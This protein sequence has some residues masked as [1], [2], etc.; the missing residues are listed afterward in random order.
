M[1]SSACRSLRSLRSRR[2]LRSLRSLRSQS[3]S[4][5][6]RSPAAILPRASATWVCQTGTSSSPVDRHRI[7]PRPRPPGPRR[8]RTGPRRS[9]TAGRAVARARPVHDG[10]TRPWCPGGSVGWPSAMASALVMAGTTDASA[11]TTSAIPPSA[12]RKRHGESHSATLACAETNPSQG[13]RTF[14]PGRPFTRTPQAGHTP[15]SP[16]SSPGR[17]SSYENGY[18]NHG[19]FARGSVAV[20]RHST[21]RVCVEPSGPVADRARDQVAAS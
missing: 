14:A 6:R 17:R 10:M 20:P 13:R 5:E 9:I 15:S 11:S 7:R 18:R 12:R 1:Y 3:E 19:E 2:S 8:G 4:G 21:R 16:S